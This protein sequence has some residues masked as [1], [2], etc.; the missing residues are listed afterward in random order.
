MKNLHIYDAERYVIAASVNGNYH[1]LFQIMFSKK[2]GS[3][4]ACFP[5]LEDCGGRL[6]IVRSLILYGVLMK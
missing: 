2:D 3:L 1:M 4:F 5:Y 6:G